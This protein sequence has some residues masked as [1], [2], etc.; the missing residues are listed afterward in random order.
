FKKL[1]ESDIEISNLHNRY[2]DILHLL[3]LSILLEMDMTLLKKIID[4]INRDHLED[5]LIDF[6][7]KYKVVDWNRNSNIFLHDTPYQSFDEIIEVSDKISAAN[8]LKHYL[9]KEWYP[10]HRD[11]GW[12]D[13]HK[14]KEDLYSGYWSFESAAVVKI[15]GLDDTSFKNN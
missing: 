9:E 11:S 2:V 10:G 13:T 1:L 14:E 12:Y 7:I 15:M 6:I 5:K 8:R 3:S 4:L